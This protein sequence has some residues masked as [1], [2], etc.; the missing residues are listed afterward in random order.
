VERDQR[1]GKEKW[2]KLTDDDLTAVEEGEKNSWGFCS[3]GKECNKQR[4]QQ[5]KENVA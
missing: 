4:R 3:R 5:Q 2:S 1:G